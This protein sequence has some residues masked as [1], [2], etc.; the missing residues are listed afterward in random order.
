MIHVWFIAGM[1][2]LG[3]SKGLLSRTPLRLCPSCG[4]YIRG[5]HCGCN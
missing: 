3:L 1:L 4:R 2:L 5:G